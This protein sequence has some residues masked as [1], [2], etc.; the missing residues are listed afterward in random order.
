MGQA[1]IIPRPT[2]TRARQT[3]RSFRIAHTRPWDGP[4]LGEYPRLFAFASNPKNITLTMAAQM[5][6]RSPRRNLP[7]APN[8][9]VTEG[10]SALTDHPEMPGWDRG[11]AGPP[12]GSEGDWD[13]RAWGI[14]MGGSSGREQRNGTSRSGR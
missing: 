8:R 10:L 1:I 14:P 13:R 11:S 3:Q 6:R 9:L 2:K 12:A 4:S 7:T 5:A